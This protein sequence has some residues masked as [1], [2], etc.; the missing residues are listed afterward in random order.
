MYPIEEVVIP[1]PGQFKSFPQ[2][3]YYLLSLLQP[4]QRPSS[5]SLTASAYSYYLMFHFR[6]IAV[7][8]RTRTVSSKASR[9]HYHS[10][11]G[12]KVRSI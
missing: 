12:W 5:Y 4:S 9:R 8:S 2:L 10:F 6:S 7:F 3:V 1:N 11:Y